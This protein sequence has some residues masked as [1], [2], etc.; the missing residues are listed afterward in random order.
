[1]K[2]NS[3]Q[4]ANLLES[5][6]VGKASAT[7]ANYVFS[8][9]DRLEKEAAEL[10]KQTMV[11]EDRNYGLDEVDI[12][13]FL[14]HLKNGDPDELEYRK[15]L[16]NAMVNSVYIYSGND[17]GHKVTI[18]FNVSNQPP[19]KVDVS[20][21]DEIRDNGGSYTSL[22]SPPQQSNPNPLSLSERRSDLLFYGTS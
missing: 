15:L 11:E 13:Y 9:I 12:M 16:V 21:L 17:G 3:K 22:S 14:S 2:E 18:I 5:L 8:E 4:K 6:K 20:L 19:V 7:A 10:E 1:M